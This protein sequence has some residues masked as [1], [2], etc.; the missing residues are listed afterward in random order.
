MNR[1]AAR[2]VQ[3]TVAL[4][5][6]GAALAASGP[7]ATPDPGPGRL[8]V[9][10]SAQPTEAHPTDRDR[11]YD[12]HLTG[13]A[14]LDAHAV[15]TSSAGCD[16][17]RGLATTVQVIVGRPGAA[18]VDNV[19][20]AWSRCADCRAS[21]VSLQ[22]V[23]LATAGPVVARNRS[24]AV[25]AGCLRC[26]AAA[27]A[28][29]T[30]VVAKDAWLSGAAARGALDT[31]AREQA[32]A[33]LTQVA[34]RAGGSMARQQDVATASGLGRLRSLLEQD[35]GARV[36]KVKGLVRLNR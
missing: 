26:K 35:A 1:W 7:A 21:A 30:V 8:D 22:V 32:R 3:T 34:A 24:L 17:C 20:T 19:A 29:Q 9:V 10:S 25:T 13:T 4:L 16:G 27:G 2:G 28:Y 33:Q 6:A 18:R 12:V 31:W 11:V 5:L 23:V 15:A 14:D 36:L